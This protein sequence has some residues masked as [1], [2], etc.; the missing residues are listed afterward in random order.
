MIRLGKTKNI[1]Y[2]I[3]IQKTASK[4]WQVVQLDQEAAILERGC[5]LT[6]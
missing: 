4:S 1:V 6:C 2:Q 5:L 3:P